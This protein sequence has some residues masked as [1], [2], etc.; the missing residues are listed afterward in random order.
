[1]FSKSSRFYDA[2]YDAAGKDYRREADAVLE[3]VRA[4]NPGATTLLDVACGTGRHLEVFADHLTC[5]GVDLDEDLLDQASRRCPAVR[6]QQGDMTDLALGA[7]FDVVTCLFSS[8]A[9]TVTANRLRAAV[10]S[11]ADHLNPGGVLVVEPFVSPE[12]WM[13]GHT[14]AIFIDEPDLKA[15]RIDTSERRDDRVTLFLHYLIG[16][17]GDIEYLREDHELGL[18]RTEDHLSAFEEAGLEVEFDEVG[19]IGRGLVVG[20]RSEP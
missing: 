20:V 15:A 11:M 2:F 8:I 12:R 9:Y 18:F 19:L 1:V 4:H 16:A 5:T 7:S 14:G 10:S 17:G 6:F 13:T 3:I